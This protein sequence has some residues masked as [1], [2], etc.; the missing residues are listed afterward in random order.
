M[1]EPKEPLGLAWITILLLPDGTVSEPE[2][3]EWWLAIRDRECD[4]R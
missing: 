1:K 4:D 3:G 2:E